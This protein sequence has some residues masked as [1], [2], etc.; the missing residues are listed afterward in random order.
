MTNK[1]KI[2]IVGDG[3]VGKTSL[4]NN[5]LNANFEE[6][7]LSTQNINILQNNEFIFYDFP[8]QEK[9]SHDINLEDIDIC[10]IMYDITNKIS[11][12]NIKFWI[13]KIQKICGNIPTIIVGNKIDCLYTSFIDNNTINISTKTQYNINNLLEIIQES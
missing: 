13:Q 6:K 5:Y 7:Y 12:K 8:G 4:I 1:K 9:Y 2:L 10:I 11:Y 3:G